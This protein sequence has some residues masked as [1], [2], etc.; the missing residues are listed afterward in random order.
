VEAERQT[1]VNKSFRIRTIFTKIK[2]MSQGISLMMMMMM[3][4]MIII[5]I[6]IIIIHRDLRAFAKCN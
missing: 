6:I 1:N 5:I 2:R 4:M 3:M